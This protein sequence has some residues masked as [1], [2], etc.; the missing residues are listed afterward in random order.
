MQMKKWIIMVVATAMAI[1]A[2]AA[3]VTGS[4]KFDGTAPKMRRIKMDADPKCAEMHAD[5][6]VTSEEV[7]VNENGTLRNVFVYV[8]SGLEGKTFEV[9]KTPVELRQEGCMY[10]PRV[11]GMMAKQPLKIHNDDDT[12][13]NVHAMPSKSKEFNI[14]QPNKGM[15]TT[16]TFAAPEAMVKFKCDVHPWMAAYVGV[17]EHPFYATTGEDGSFTLKDLPAGTY[18]IVAW[19]EKLGEQTAKVT[20]ADAP[21]TQEFTFKAA[22]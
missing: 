11:F 8:K 2:H 3:D 4:V 20:V 7:I 14:G 12:L 22:E 13:H 18:E 10:K 21:V 17:M 16:R 6:P 9:P 1:S 19:H 15:E 5:E